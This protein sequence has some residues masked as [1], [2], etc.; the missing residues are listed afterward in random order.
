MEMFSNELFITINKWSTIF[1]IHHGK[2]WKYRAN[3][4][5]VN[6]SLQEICIVSIMVVAMDSM[7]MVATTMEMEISLLEDMLELRTKSLNVGKSLSSDTTVK[8][9]CSGD[10]PC[11]I[12]IKPLQ[13]T[14]TT[15]K[16][17]KIKKLLIYYKRT[18]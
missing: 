7:L 5:I 9:T 11:Y 1:L 3:K 14:I 16:E 13:K 18:E 12:N 8:N 6:L 10:Q 2:G 15:A 17:R 4:R